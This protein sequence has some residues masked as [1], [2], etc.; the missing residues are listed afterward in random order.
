MSEEEKRTMEKLQ[1]N[2]EKNFPILS[3]SI[4]ELKIADFKKIYSRK[5]MMNFNEFKE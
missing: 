3:N 1:E 2:I 5:M 4:E